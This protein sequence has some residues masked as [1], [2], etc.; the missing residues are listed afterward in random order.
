[1]SV[2]FS[3][4]GDEMQSLY[5]LAWSRKPASTAGA[6]DPVFSGYHV[7]EPAVEVAEDAT[8]EEAEVLAAEMAM[9]SVTDP[10]AQELEWMR[11]RKRWES[12]RVLHLFKLGFT[13]L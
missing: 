2:K 6:E 4:K 8:A 10:T 5:S 1:M 12:E 9:Q 3:M 11:S 13:D 7:V